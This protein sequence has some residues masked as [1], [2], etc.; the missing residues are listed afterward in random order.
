MQKGLE[1]WSRVRWNSGTKKMSLFGGTMEWILNEFHDLWY[2]R[3]TTP[4]TPHRGQERQ[5]SYSL[6]FRR[7][8]SP[9]TSLSLK[10]RAF[11]DVAL[12]SWRR[13][14]GPS[15]I[16]ETR[17]ESIGTRLSSWLERSCFL[18]ASVIELIQETKIHHSRRLFR[19]KY[20]GISDPFMH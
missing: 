3:Y 15:L 17:N 4:P 19:H 2:F 6:S 18:K 9:L 1:K 8:S 11:P 12:R 16:P 7:P 13:W 10:F 5:R 20:Q 14:C